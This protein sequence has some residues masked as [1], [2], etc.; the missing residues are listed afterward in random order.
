VF[1]I[2]DSVMLGA[3]NGVESA[4]PVARFTAV[5]GWQER[6]VSRAISRALPKL[7]QYGVLLNLGNNGFIAEDSVRELLG[8]LRSQP[9]VVIV[10]ASVPRRWQDGNNALLRRWQ[11]TTQMS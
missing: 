10:N 4:L 3:R 6:D 8:S 5:V 1:A 9:R 11:W 7:G 2:G